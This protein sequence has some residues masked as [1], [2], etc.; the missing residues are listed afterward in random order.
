MAMSIS[1]RRGMPGQPPDRP[2]VPYRRNR[3]P[4]ALHAFAVGIDSVVPVVKEADMNTE[5]RKRRA[6]ARLRAHQAPGLGRRLAGKGLRS[7]IF[8]MLFLGLIGLLLGV[9]LGG[10]ISA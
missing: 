4:P 6:S 9:M 3:N 2:N 10:V 5:A 1:V 7:W 8:T